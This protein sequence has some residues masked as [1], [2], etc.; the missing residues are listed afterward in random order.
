MCCLQVYSNAFQTLALIQ[1]LENTSFPWD[2]ITSNAK[3]SKLQA[4]EPKLIALRPHIGKTW[5][6][7]VCSRSIESL[8]SFFPLPE[9][10]PPLTAAN[11]QRKQERPEQLGVGTDI[12][13]WGRS[14]PPSLNSLSLYL[15]SSP[16]LICLS[17]WHQLCSQAHDCRQRLV[18]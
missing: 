11:S 4:I 8:T 16:R 1:Y 12:L 10:Y 14:P 6:V 3:T 15:F 7:W 13:F 5:K 9:F 2:W 17:A 18:L